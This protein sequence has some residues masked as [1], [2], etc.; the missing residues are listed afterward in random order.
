MVPDFGSSRGESTTTKIGFSPGNVIA[1]PWF[2][3]SSN[4]HRTWQSD[5]L[6]WATGGNFGMKY[7]F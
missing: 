4:L 6:Y 7:D 1:Q 3:I 2:K 5:I